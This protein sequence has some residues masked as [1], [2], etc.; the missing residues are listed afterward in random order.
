MVV[1]RRAAGEREALRMQIQ[2]GL[3]L[4]SGSLR[5]ECQRERSRGDVLEP[6]AFDVDLGRMSNRGI[7]SAKV[8]DA[9]ARLHEDRHSIPGGLFGQSGWEERTDRV[10]AW[11]FGVEGEV[12]RVGRIGRVKGGVHLTQIDG[13]VDDAATRRGTGD[14]GLDV[15]GLPFDARG[16]VRE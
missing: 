10:E 2:V 3:V 14:V 9:A 1:A 8:L 4:E 5:F 7:P 15:A 11:C 12:E 13:S 6:R 16:S